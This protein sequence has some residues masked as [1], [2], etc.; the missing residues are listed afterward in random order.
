MLFGTT[1]KIELI[2]GLRRRLTMFGSMFLKSI[3]VPLLSNFPNVFHPTFFEAHWPVE[4]FR[5]AKNQKVAL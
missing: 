2:S 3:E 1:L 5:S 4:I